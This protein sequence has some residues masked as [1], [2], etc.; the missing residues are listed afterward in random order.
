MAFRL[1]RDD[2]Q[3]LISRIDQVYVHGEVQVMNCSIVVGSIEVGASELWAMKWI[4]KLGAA[5]HERA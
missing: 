3:R 5:L 4:V 1:A 2:E